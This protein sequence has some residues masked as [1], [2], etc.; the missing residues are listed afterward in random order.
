MEPILLGQ[1]DSINQTCQA[2]SQFSWQQEKDGIEDAHKHMEKRATAEQ[3]FGF[4]RFQ[5]FSILSPVAVQV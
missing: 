3:D 5:I 4:I 1:N 2:L